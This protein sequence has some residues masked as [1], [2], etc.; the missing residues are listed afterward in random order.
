MIT[1]TMT[2]DHRV[3]NGAEAAVF[4]GELKALLKEPLRVVV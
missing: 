3:L 2:V 1:M 4:L